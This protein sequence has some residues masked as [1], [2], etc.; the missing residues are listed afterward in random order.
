MF[1]FL[2]SWFAGQGGLKIS[3]TRV[4]TLPNLR[5]LTILPAD[6]RLAHRPM[7]ALS[8]F[9]TTSICLVRAHMYLVVK[10]RIRPL[11]TRLAWP[12]HRK[13]YFPTIILS[14]AL[15]RWDNMMSRWQC[16]WESSSPCTATSA[17]LWRWRWLGKRRRGTLTVTDL[18]TIDG[19]HLSLMEAPTRSREPFELPIWWEWDH[20]WSPPSPSLLFFA[21][22]KSHKRQRKCNFLSLS[23]PKVESESSNS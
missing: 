4:Q 19:C 18:A 6:I 3:C 21:T 8:K 1:G 16:D 13:T 10:R 17:L 2:Y 20:R 7:Y 22:K 15:R 12:R 14:G 11:F 9:C 5:L 23:N